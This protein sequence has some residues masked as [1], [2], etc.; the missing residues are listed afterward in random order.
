[1]PK[2]VIIPAA[3]GPGVVPPIPEQSIRFD[4]TRATNLRGYSPLGGSEDS[5]SISCWI[6]R[7]GD[8]NTVQTLF[9][10][11]INATNLMRVYFD[12]LNRLNYETTVGG[13]VVSENRTFRLFLDV[14]NW[15]H[16]LLTFNANTQ[17]RW[18]VNGYLYPGVQQLVI[19]TPGDGVGF[20]WLKAGTEHFIG[21]NALN[22]DN[23]SGLMSDLHV[24]YEPPEPPADQELQFTPSKDESPVAMQSG[25]HGNVGDVRKAVRLW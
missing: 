5:W 23:F 18:D 21:S 16:L 15:F 9:E 11:R 24:R 25:E 17:I 13:V 1:M 19:A 4:R 3:G 20:S 14:T 6:K 2:N 8:L 22:A 12:S 7:T 10:S